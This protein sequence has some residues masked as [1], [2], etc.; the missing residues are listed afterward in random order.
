ML[1]TLYS[2]FNHLVRVWVKKIYLLFIQ[3]YLGG[4]ISL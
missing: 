3:P 1:F 2:V 4:T